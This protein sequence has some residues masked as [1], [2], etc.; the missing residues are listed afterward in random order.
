MKHIKK[1]ISLL[2]VFIILCTTCVGF[3][4]CSKGSVEMSVGDYLITLIDEFGMYLGSEELNDNIALSVAKEWE[5]VDDKNLNTEENVQKGFVLTTLVKTVGFYETENLTD[6]DIA[7]YGAKNGYSAFSYKSSKDFYD[8]ANK[9]ETIESINNAKQIW[10]NP[11]FEENTNVKLK[12]DVLDLSTYTYDEQETSSIEVD[13]LNDISSETADI[14]DLLSNDFNSLESSDRNVVVIYGKVDIEKGQTY[15][16]PTLGANASNEI[17]NVEDVEYRDGKTYIINSDQE[18]DIETVLETAEFSGSGIDDLTTVPIVDGNGIVHYP[19][20]S[21]SISNMSTVSN[22]PVVTNMAYNL[23]NAKS[24]YLGTLSNPSVENTAVSGE[25]KI[26]FGPLSASITTSKDSFKCKI[27]GEIDPEKLNN[28]INDKLKDKLGEK[29]EVKAKIKVDSGIE[30]K[31][32]S[33]DYNVDLFKRN[34]YISVSGTQVNS[35][36]AKVQVAAKGNYP[37]GET[38]VENLPEKPSA[39]ITKTLAK[40]PIKSVGV[41]SICLLIKAKIAIDGSIEYVVTTQSTYGA[42]VKKGNLR[43]IKDV[44]RDKD[45]N[46]K[47][48]IEG[49]VYI[50]PAIYVGKT[51]AFSL[52]FEGGLGAEYKLTIHVYDKQTKEQL[53]YQEVGNDIQEFGN[54]ESTDSKGVDFCHDVNVYWILKAKV[55]TESWL[56]EKLKISFEAEIFGKKNASFID[57]HYEDGKEVSECTRK[58]DRE[59]TTLDN[60]DNNYS[61]NIETQELNSSIY[62]GKTSSIQISALP[63]GYKKSDL[64]FISNDNSVVTVDSNGT[65]TGKKSGSTTITIS[66]SDGKYSVEYAV[67]VLEK[68]AFFEEDC[69]VYDEVLSI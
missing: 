21:T 13:N 66:T 23:P 42:E 47:A 63:K 38:K 50:G 35:I 49:T 15:V 2:L 37:I 19:D 64:N 52:G 18:V 55:D 1:I 34:A 65:I 16:S 28:K 22:S 44:N 69:L 48:K 43:L 7:E 33:A 51:N 9:E 68:L 36:G 5:V 30:I 20:G 29:N 8:K 61:S 26:E 45:V 17:Y 31:D 57:K 40:V 62:E 10:L 3:S 53:F 58:Y 56:A 25:I 11:N 39:V 54:I 41:A 46:I 27:S 60:E 67:F 32:I 24:S 59:S 14:D 6:E 4:A 12:D